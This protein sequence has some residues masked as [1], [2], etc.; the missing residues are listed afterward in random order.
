MKARLR[1]YFETHFSSQ[2]VRTY[3]RV[4]LQFMD[5]CDKENINPA[6]ANI[7]ELY[8]YK[9][10][11]IDQGYA[12]GTIRQNLQVLKYFYRAIKRKDNPALLVKHAKLERT[13]PQFLLSKDQLEEVYLSIETRGLTQRRNKCLMGVLIFQGLKL[14]EIE[15]LKL[16]DLDPTNWTIRIAKTSKT[17]SRTIQLD[18]VQIKD[19]MDY[20]YEYR[21]KL[22]DERGCDSD[23]LF[24]SL[25]TGHQL[26]N[27][28]N[29]MLRYVKALNPQV[30]SSMQIR[31]S[32]MSVWVS[33][34]GLRKAQ[35]LSGVRYASSML[36]YQTKDI[37]SLK[38][39]L[40]IVH[41]MQGMVN[42][43][44]L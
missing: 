1:T 5:W 32:R 38:Q 7:D 2:T 18:I 6:T 20:V 3:L 22:L 16:T 39:K 33:E 34:Y 27:A 14:G 28:I 41:P 15:A 13:K 35:Y 9:G 25:G 40:E 8:R 12:E 11:L 37:E 17:N 21:P 10:D 36:R 19:M 30:K 31:Q 26:N 24:F 44:Y 23:N 29:G 4:C 42:K 43:G